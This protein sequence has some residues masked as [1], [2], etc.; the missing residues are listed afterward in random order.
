MSDPVGNTEDRFSCVAA[1]IQ[2]GTVI[3]QIT[4]QWPKQNFTQT[5]DASVLVVFGILLTVR[6]MHGC[7]NQC[8]SLKKNQIKKEK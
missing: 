4:N 3:Y 8:V 6:C 7:T 5:C 1:Y 2:V